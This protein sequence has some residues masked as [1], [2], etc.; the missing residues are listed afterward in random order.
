MCILQRQHID[1]ETFQELTKLFLMFSLNSLPISKME[2]SIPNML[3]PRNLG[4]AVL[5]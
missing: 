1:Q 5:N 2:D 3:N 4:A